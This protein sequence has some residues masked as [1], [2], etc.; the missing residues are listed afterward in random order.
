MSSDAAKNAYPDP[1]DEEFGSWADWAAHQFR[2]DELDGL[3]EAYDRGAREAL[4]RAARQCY[5]GA[6]GKFQAYYDN[7]VALWLELMAIE[8]GQGMSREA[9]T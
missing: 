7:G 2:G 3:R 8:H 1:A 6:P 4:M 9:G 5:N